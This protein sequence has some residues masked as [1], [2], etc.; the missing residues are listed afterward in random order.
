MLG[1]DDP[2]VGV[3]FTRD[4][5][6]LGDALQPRATSSLAR[7]WHTGSA[8][9]TS[10]RPEI[11][12]PPSASGECAHPGEIGLGRIASRVLDCDVTGRCVVGRR[13][14]AK[15]SREYLRRT[16]QR[17]PGWADK[18]STWLF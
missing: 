14:A 17:H 18:S 8:T 15:R 2:G 9:R 11:K 12:G 5:Q 4:S 10:G 1:L 13:E 3:A 6:M 16:P 7:A